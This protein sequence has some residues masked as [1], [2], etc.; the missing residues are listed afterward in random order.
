[1][2]AAIDLT[3][4]AAGTGGFVIVGRDAGDNTGF[5]VASA[6][7]VNGDGFDDL[8]LGAYLGDGSG[9]AKSN[10]G[11]SYVVFGKA[12]GFGASIDLATIATGTGGF[13]IYG[14]DVADN[15]GI[16]VASAGDINGDGFDDLLIGAPGGDAAGNAKGGAGESYVIYGKAASFGASVDL[17]AVAAGTGGFVI[18]GQDATDLSGYSVA[19]AGDINGDGFADMII[20]A[21]GGDAAGGAKSGAGDTYI[22]FGKSTG[23][24]ASV[25]LTTIAAGTGGFVIF[26]ADANDKSGTSVAAAGDINGDG[27]GDLIIGASEGDGPNNTTP[28]AGET[29]VLFG[30]TTPFGA[31]VDL[32]A[33][34]GGTGGFVIYNN[35]T[36]DRSGSSV[37]S[38]GDINGDGFDDLVLGVANA[39][40]VNNLKSYSGDTY[41]VFGKSTSFGS[42]ISLGSIASG[43]GGF[44]IYGQ[45]AGDQSGFSVAGAGDVN[46]D[47]FDDLLIGARFGA[48]AANGKNRA[49]ESYV[50]F[51]KASGFGASIDLA[52][53]AAGTGGFI[54]YG[55]DPN[56]QAGSS[57]A[58]AG[59]ING[60]G[61]DDLLIG[62]PLGDA[63]TNS[64]ADAGDSYVIFGKDF[65]AV[66]T[67][68]GTSGAD[69]LAGSANA[70]VMIGGLGNDTL[71]GLGGADALRGGAG[72]DV[73]T[74][75]A[76]ADRIDGGSGRDTADYALSATAVNVNLA[77]SANTGGDAQGDLLNDIENVSGSAFG[78]NLTG[79]ALANVFSGAGGNDTLKG[80]AG[81]DTL[82]GDAGIDTAVYSGLKST[83]TITKAAGSVTVSGAD[84]TDVLTGV[85]KLSFSDATVN[86]GKPAVSDFNADGNSDLLWLRQSD[87]Y[88]YLWTMTNNAQSGGGALGQVGA[89]WTIQT[90]GDFNG[91]GSSDFI[92]KNTAT[93]Q[94][95]IWNFT[96][97]VQSGGASI[98]SIGTNWNVMGSGDFNAD[99]TGDIVWRDSNTGQLYLWMMQNNGI[100]SSTNLGAIG[101]DWTV[102]AVGDF[103][104]DGTSDLALRNTSTGQAY[105][106]NFTN[107]TLSG[108]NN[109]GNVVTNWQIMG[110]GD[111]NADGTDDLAWRNSTD[112]KLNLWMM[113]NN[114]ISSTSDLGTIGTQWTIDAISDVNADGTSDLL[115]KN[116]SSGQFYIWDITNGVVSGGAD[117]GLIG[118]DWQL[119]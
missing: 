95:Y 20:S 18:Y 33:V 61:F 21:R 104:G 89:D 32:T 63:A 101:V 118:A 79:D 1:M 35:D 24:G 86:L 13:A 41:V 113:Q 74:G 28:G 103:N 48:A 15:A 36:N 44:V 26:G 66:V 110:S 94:F 40:G 25:D 46:G 98:G 12:G 70:D 64:K 109:L 3:T 38:A 69:S 30:K 39:D 111:F 75:G 6:G 51:G 84:G 65:S 43:S 17:S 90:T 115:L 60:D 37:A 100:A 116:S 11:D 83:Y 114:A 58:A 68:A 45:E 34:A 29:Y 81:N 27:L 82:S 57:V 80:G 73:L 4:I 92:W 78:D 97:G 96:N 91:D 52:T 59:D 50:V 88:A 117:L 10:A 77:T 23:F 112:G 87:G 53:V 71:S 31:S 119:V 22:V 5:S 16:S 106:W 102:Q 54:I 55:Q 9:N 47:G 108:G 19:S 72:D 2:P 107:G 7:D 14:Q 67:Q 56:D 105:L 49:G 93:G 85:E 8:I 42:S 99:G 76:G 62:A